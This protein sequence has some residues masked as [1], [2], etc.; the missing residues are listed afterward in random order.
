MCEIILNVWIEFLYFFYLMF[1]LISESFSKEYYKCIH[2]AFDVQCP[3]NRAFLARDILF[4]ENKFWTSDV[5]RRTS[6]AILYNIIYQC[7]ND[8]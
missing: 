6:D 3:N 4:L 8:L 1:L 2:T 5:V 7:I